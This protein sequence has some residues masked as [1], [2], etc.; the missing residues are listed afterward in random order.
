MA[1]NPL[2]GSAL[3]STG[4]GLLGGLMGGSGTSYK[5]TRSLNRQAYQ[6]AMKA[7]I[8]LGENARRSAE[9]SGFNPLTML[10]AMGGAASGFGGNSFAGGPPLAS[11]AILTAAQGV[12]DI[13][14]TKASLDQQERQFQQAR[15]D[16]KQNESAG[17]ETARL[18]SRG[19]QMQPGSGM[20][21]STLAVPTQQVSQSPMRTQSAG[22][23]VESQGL[24][25]PVMPERPPEVQPSIQEYAIPGGATVALPEIDV[26]SL[27]EI[28]VLLPI[29][30]GQRM[31]DAVD[32]WSD[33][34]AREERKIWRRQTLP[35]LN[36]LD[37]GRPVTAS[38]FRQ[39]DE[40]LTDMERRILRQQEGK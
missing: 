22:A 6:H 7:Q 29:Y 1:I 13:L 40:L 5:R 36:E 12:S 9:R 10:G 25:A 2:I 33:P 35:R 28:P 24:G 34:S 32:E 37:K 16:A 27:G 18:G 4:G 19:I 39:G 14:M 20:A 17:F 26:P 31:M 21:P 8:R 11:N 38:D 23:I 15:D 3:I 30:T